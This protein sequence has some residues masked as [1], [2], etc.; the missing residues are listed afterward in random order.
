M[1]VQDSM[2]TTVHQDE[3]SKIDVEEMEILLKIGEENNKVSKSRLHYGFNYETD[4]IP[5]LSNNSEREFLA[6]SIYKRS[7]IEV[8]FPDNT[9]QEPVATFNRGWAW[10]NEW[11]LLYF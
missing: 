10:Q 9:K 4:S 11:S 2:S 8:T 5:E 6:E 3:D 7:N 1:T